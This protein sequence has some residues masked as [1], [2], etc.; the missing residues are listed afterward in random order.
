[1]IRLF[2]P[3]L[4]RY[5]TLTSFYGNG[6][7]VD[8]HRDGQTRMRRAVNEGA[9]LFDSCLAKA[10][11][12]DDGFAVGVRVV[13]MKG[14]G[15]IRREKKELDI[16]ARVIVDASGWQ[17]VLY[18]DAPDDWG[19]DK[20]MGPGERIDSSRDIVE[21][22]DPEADGA[23]ALDPDNLDIIMTERYGPGG[24]VWRFPAR[25][26]ARIVN[27]G[28][29]VAI[30]PGA[31]KSRALLEEYYRFDPVFHEFRRIKSATWPIPNRRPRAKLVANGFAV[32]G[33]AAIQINPATAE[34]IG[35]GIGAAWYLGEAVCGVFEGGGRPTEGNLWEYAHAYMTSPEYGLRQVKFD[36]FRILLQGS[37]DRDFDGAFA[38]GLIREEELQ[39]ASEEEVDLGLLDKLKR[40]VV[41]AAT[42]HLA[43]LRRLDHC[44][45]M[46]SRVQELYRGYP[47]TPN[48][49]LEWKEREN[50]FFR[51][52]QRR[53]NPS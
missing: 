32:L 35:Y 50:V 40:G 33:D 46:M 21:V 51:V 43:L 27:V 42:G 30:R 53:L 4:E 39:R 9:E 16:K 7:M 38:H 44:L 28:N 25:E 17:G 19:M 13:Q 1:G 12:L 23:V 49:Y 41:A 11:L 20:E 6:Y 29:G 2:P 22:R 8:R 37:S 36:V 14:K 24:Y 5:Y 52:T 48:G 10:L 3:S 34:G 18:R 47:E 31:P 45:D 26:D 15:R